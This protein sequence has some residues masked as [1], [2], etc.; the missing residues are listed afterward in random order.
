MPTSC[1]HYFQATLRG[2]ERCGLDAD[3]LLANV[4]LDRDSVFDPAWRGDVELL[5]RLVQLVWYALDDEFMG[6]LASPARP[7]TFAMMAHT[8]LAEPS[9]ERALR[10]GVLFYSLV[11]DSM[12]M[13]LTDDPETVRLSI[14]F[15]R[16][17]LD[18]E[19]YFLEFWTTIWYRLIGW[20]AGA[21]PPLRKVT[22]AYP[23]P[24]AYADELRYIFRCEH[25]FDSDETAIWFDRSFL[26]QPVVRTRAELKQFLSVAPV[27]FM[28]VPGDEESMARRV[29]TSLQAGRTLPLDFPPL[30]ELARQ[31]NLAEPTLRRRLREESTSYREI[32]ESIRRDIAV[33]RLI[34][35]SMSVQQIGELVGYAETRAFTRAFKHWTGLSP[36]QYRAHIARQFRPE[37]PMGHP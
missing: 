3:V 19:H 16:P 33:Q 32:K 1:A 12:R 8:A 22:F 17:E 30:A 24:S 31:L 23:R 21:L 36:G 11:C 37:D 14:T 35:S 4:G 34:G 2:A 13:T 9:V 25:V 20:L 27:G 18:P 10:K 26:Q 15:A 6:F 5:A 29:R 28:M 7:G